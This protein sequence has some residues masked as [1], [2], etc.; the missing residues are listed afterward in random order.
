MDQT[1]L[2]EQIALYY[3][4]LSP[5]MQEVFSSMKWMESLQDISKKYSL[6]E[7]QIETLG[8]ET[9]LALLGIISLEEYDKAIENEL[10]M[11]ST[12]AIK[13]A[14]ELDT[15]ILKAL[16]PELAVAHDA[17]IKSLVEEKYGGTQNLDE[18]FSKLPKEVQVAISESNYQIT[19]YEIAESFDLSIDQ[20][21]T[22]EEATTKVMIGVTHPDEYEAKLEEKLDLPKEKIAD[23][24]NDVNEKVLKNIREILKSHWNDKKDSVGTIDDDVPTPPYKITENL[25]Q[26]IITTREKLP[27][28]PKDQQLANTV[29]L[30]TESG[31]YKKAGIEMI[32]DKSKDLSSAT[33]VENDKMSIKDD[34]LLMKSGVQMI[35]DKLSRPTVS[36]S[37]VTDHSLPKIQ[38]KVAEKPIDTTS[39]TKTHDPYHEEIV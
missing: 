3:S 7:E 38:E 33:P 16:R 28:K 10:G 21:A 26:N 29:S 13:M 14:A 25:A 34:V 19:L 8:T 23:L 24:V 2:Q 20:M 9:T 6:N 30:K 31:I 36:N 18:R 17:H 12:V 37:S 27:E 32:D 1:K 5:S 35:A 22:L 11:E 15:F 39:T 4:K